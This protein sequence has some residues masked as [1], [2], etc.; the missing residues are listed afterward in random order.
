MNVPTH[1]DYVPSIFPCQKGKKQEGKIERYQRAARR[2]MIAGIV[3]CLTNS[4]LL[5]SRRHF[6]YK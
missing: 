4:M 1:P 5:K 6:I 2:Q 3:K